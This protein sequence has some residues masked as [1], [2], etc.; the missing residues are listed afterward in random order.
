MFSK[1]EDAKTSFLEQTKAAREERA[2]EKK[3]E[4]SAVL[5]QAHIRGWLARI[6]FT[7]YILNDFDV[8]VPDVPEDK[9]NL[10]SFTPSI[11]IYQKVRLFLLIWKKERDKERFAKL[12]R[13][14]IASLDSNSPKYSYVGI[15]LNKNHVI[16]WISHM[17]DILWKCCDYLDD[18]K[19]EYASDMKFVLLY[20]HMLVSFT[21]TSTWVILKNKNIEQFKPGMSK[22]CA[23]F[24]GQL[25]HRGFY[26]TLKG[27]LIKGL[28]R[29]RIVFKAASLSA[30]ITLALRP[31]IAADFSDKFMTMFLIQILSVPGIIQHLQTVTPDSI[32]VLVTNKIF[33]RSIELLSNQQAMRIVF[34]TL[35]GNYALCL[36]AN[37]TQLGYIERDTTLKEICFPSFTVV[38]TGLLESCQ[39]YVVVKQSNLTHWHP[40][41]GWFA[42]P[43]DSALHAAIPHVKMQLHLLWNSEIVNILLGKF[44]SSLVKNLEAPHAPGGSSG[45]SNHFSGTNFLRRALDSRVNKTNTQK[46]Y[47][48]LGSPEVHRVVLMCSLY[49]TALHTLTQLKLD[50]L[51]GLCYRDRFLYDL[52]LFLCSLGPNCG[53]KTFLDH[54]AVNTKCTAPEFQMLQLFSDCMTHYVTILDDMELYEQQNPFKLSDFVILS[55]FLNIFLYK[56]V[57][58][59]L[60]D[61]KSIQSNQLF[62]SLHTL[63][64]VLYKRDCRRRYTPLGH[65]LI[66]EIKVSSFMVDLEKGRRAQQILLQTMPHIIPHEDRVRLF[67][68]YIINEKTVLGLTESACASP[69]ST[70]ITVHRSRIVEDGYRQLALI[71][72]Q[73]LKGVIRVRFINEQG[74]DEAGIDQDGVFKEFLEESIKKVFDPGLNLFK[75]TSE[76]RLYPSPTSY[77]QENHLQLFEFVGRMLGKAVYEGI[78][79]DVPFASFFLSQVLGQT[80]QAL[81][82]CVDELPSLDADLYRSLNYIKHY[83]GDV[84][85][86]DLSFTADEDCLGKLVTHELIPGGKAVSVT[87]DNKINYIH[88]MAHF[89]MHVQIK[90][91]TAAFIR[92]FRSIISPEWLSLFSTPEL[93]RLIS[94]DN[95][96]LDLKDLRKHTQYYGGFHDSHRVV[97]WLWDILD[98]DFSDEEKGMFLKF[99]T[100]CSKPPLLGFA[101]LEPPFSIRCVEV[102]DDEDTG[103]TIGSVIRG[104]FTIRK[105]DPQNR[106]PTSS[107]CF[108][109]LKL[110]N[111]QKK[112]TLREK[113]RYAVSCNTGFELS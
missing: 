24:M 52:W 51:T 101:H 84:S 32:T 43:M 66:K 42:Q 56:I 1:G 107:T 103:D 6:K 55:N 60:I 33:L 63:L 16:H 93:Q 30:I 23:N 22:F 106:L 10:T 70:L 94:G 29:L 41:L 83:E 89:R 54:L 69:Q 39:H 109:L 98:K 7:N 27:L 108:N 81:Y 76:E 36:L 46:S 38:V 20:L 91:Q 100:S 8:I 48:S 15:A 59:S 5:L 99:V 95:V 50:I 80:A 104:F 97:N 65:W 72:P 75:I 53:L 14:M 62:Q 2:L 87:N 11:E 4:Q 82:S 102:G 37:I 64:I 78:V 71:L 90:D 110:P 9:V 73:N 31:L 61:L 34:N 26:L 17:N 67:R 12:C 25:F 92:G 85:E 79:V 111:Y 47:R 18:L 113:L 58:G 112:S 40:V 13:Y 57:I 74:L 49:H 35:E 3:K 105:K 68:K 96:P 44:L 77:L 19:P 21:S 88:L 45:H 28:S 86:L